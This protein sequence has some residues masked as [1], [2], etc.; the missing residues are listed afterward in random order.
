M[1][2]RSAI[3]MGILLLSGT[4]M[5]WC[6]GQD[7]LSQKARSFSISASDLAEA[8]DWANDGRNSRLKYEALALDEVGKFYYRVTRGDDNSCRELKAEF[9]S[10][11]RAFRNLKNSIRQNSLGRDY[12][13]TDAL[14]WVKDDFRSLR[15]A[16]D[17]LGRGD[18][19]D[20]GWD[21]DWNDI[22][23]YVSPHR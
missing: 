14:E 10:V 9:R 23:I 7:S 1:K 19:D 20:D 21:D 6:P 22:P 8:I 2:L 17:R 12:E 13:V 11:S 5:A 16:V 4:V 3:G 18:W 15:R